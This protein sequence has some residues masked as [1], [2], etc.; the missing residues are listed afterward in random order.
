MYVFVLT[1]HLWKIKLFLFGGDI[2]LSSFLKQ[3]EKVNFVTGVLKDG[4]SVLKA[5][6]CSPV[7]L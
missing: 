5:Y 3:E 6:L 1:L 4:K 7:I 2:L